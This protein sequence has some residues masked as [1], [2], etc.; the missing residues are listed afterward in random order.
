MKFRSSAALA[1]ALGGRRRRRPRP[2]RHRRHATRRACGST[3][4]SRASRSLAD[5]FAPGAFLTFK[6]DG[7]PSAPARPTRP[8]TSTTSRTRTPGST[9]AVR[10]QGKNVGTLQLTAEDGAGVVAAAGPRV[11][12][13]NITSPGPSGTVKPRKR[14]KFRVFGFQTEQEDLPAHPPRW[15][16]PSAASRWARPGDCGLRNQADALHAAAT[17]TRPAPTSTGSGTPRSSR[18]QTAHR[19]REVTITRTL[20]RRVDSDDRAPPPGAEP[21]SSAGPGGFS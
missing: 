17:P 3:R 9:P 15:A 19:R 7:S 1:L 13:A 5:G 10:S 4:G 12:A 6:A 14:V 2:R 16:R 11:K 18:K 21:P 8:A 20:Q